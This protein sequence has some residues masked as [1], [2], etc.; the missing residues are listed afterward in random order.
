MM[1]I[2]AVLDEDSWN[3]TLRQVVEPGRLF[4]GDTWRKRRGGQ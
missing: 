4:M 1:I 3:Q 2:I